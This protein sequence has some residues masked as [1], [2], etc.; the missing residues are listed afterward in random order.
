[1]D[2]VSEAEYKESFEFE[3]SEELIAKGEVIQ[4]IIYVAYHTINL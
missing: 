4:Y 3:I 2:A 1:M